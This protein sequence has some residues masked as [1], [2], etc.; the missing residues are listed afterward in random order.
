MLIFSL[1]DNIVAKVSSCVTQEM[2]V[3]SRDVCCVDCQILKT[4][5]QQQKTV[6]ETKLS[7]LGVWH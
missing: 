1:D 4:K 2:F 7:L 5:Q 6:D 3:D